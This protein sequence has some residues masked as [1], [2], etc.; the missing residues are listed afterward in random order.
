MGDL[1][2]PDPGARTGRPPWSEFRAALEAAGFRPSKSRGQNF[3][4]DGNM[5]RS[6]ARDSG[7]GAGDFVLEVGPGCGFLS[8]HL[9]A[10]GVRLLGVEI[11]GRLL[12]VARRFLAPFEDVVFVEADVLAGKHRLA[13][14]VAGRLPTDDD[15]HLVSNL[16]YSVAG[17]LLV[18]LSRLAHPPRS[19][20]ALVQREVAE[21]ITA[22]P[23]EKGWGVLGAKLAPLYRREAG[24]RVPAGLFWPRPRVESAVVRL[25]RRPEDPGALGAYDALVER[26]FQH[27]RKAVGGTL[28]G[29]LG[30][31]DRA[32]ALLE[33][34]GADPRARPGTLEVETLRVLS[35]SPLWRPKSAPEGR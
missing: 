20:T 29:L 3:L 21:R 11:D 15:W 23:A 32:R 19:M 27:R 12:E 22:R 5:A 9:A 17:P 2:G 28:R 4:L 25:E 1:E 33:E 26:L 7:V 8:V 10:L 30:D 6:I 34:A 24:R 14:E 18:V 13:P 31:S 16:P 35:G